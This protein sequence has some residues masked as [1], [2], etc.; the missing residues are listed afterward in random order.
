M[1]RLG[2]A[3]Y[4]F[5]SVA[6]FYNSY[7]RIYFQIQKVHIMKNLSFLL[8]MFLLLSLS[9]CQVIGDIFKTGVGV[10]VFLVVFVI[11]II[12]FF[13]SKAAGGK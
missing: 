6:W 1:P 4:V 12:V 7:R 8:V 9:S 5:S 13:I 11:A 10:G 3:S 2:A